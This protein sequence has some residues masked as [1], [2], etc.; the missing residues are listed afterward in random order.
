MDPFLAFA[1]LARQRRL[2]AAI[3]LLLERA[4][5][6]D[7]G[8]TMRGLRHTLE[9]I[10]QPE[11][12]VLTAI[13]M[14]NASRPQAGARLWSVRELGVLRD[15]RSLDTVI[16]ALDDPAREVRVMA[17]HSLA[18]ICQTQH[19]C[20]AAA[21]TALSMYCKKRDDLMNNGPAA[22]QLQ[23]LAI[24]DRIWRNIALQHHPTSACNR[25]LR[26]RD[27]GFSPG[28]LRRTRF[29]VL[30]RFAPGACGG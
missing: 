24:C 23:V 28:S 18:M 16:R 14:D 10:V 19:A 25:P 22:R 4:S 11:W 15:P 17:C 9:A 1:E 29:R 21:L 5:Y 26:A 12:D 3:P 2:R 30:A 20:R 27:H 13:C 7:P 8:E 6:G